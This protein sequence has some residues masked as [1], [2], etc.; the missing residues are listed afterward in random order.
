MSPKFAEGQD[1]QA[2]TERLNVLTSSGW[3]L[4][5]EEIRL[6]KTYWLKTY[7]KVLVRRSTFV[8]MTSTMA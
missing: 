5:A 7:T 3:T 4:D 8:V 2:L 6:Q 1:T